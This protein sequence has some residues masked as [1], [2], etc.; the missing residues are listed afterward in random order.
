MS[1]TYDCIVIGGGPAGSTVAA[2]VAEAGFRTLLLE[3]ETLPRYRVGESLMPEAWWTLKRLGLVEPLKASRYPRKH[4]VKLVDP[5]GCDCQPFYFCEADPRQCSLAWQVV[6]SEFDELLF[7]QAAKMGAECRDQTCV[8]EVLFDGPA[9]CGVRVQGAAAGDGSTRSPGAAGEDAARPGGSRLADAESLRGPVREIRGKVIVDAAGAAS[10]LAQA[11]ELREPD[12]QGD[13]SAIWAYYVGA[14]RE[15]GI[16]EGT[17][18]LLQTR[19]RRAWFWYLPL[20]DDLVSVGVVADRE[21]LLK[22]RGRPE[23]VFE[24]E[25]VN[26]PAVARRLIDAR[27][28]RQFRVAR[29]LSYRCTRAS[30]PSWVL[31]GDALGAVDPLLGAGVFLAL[32]SGEL[33]ADCIIEGLQRGDLSAEQLGRWSGCFEQGVGRLRKLSAQMYHPD[34]SV[35]TLTQQAPQYKQRWSDLLAG[36]IFHLTD[37]IDELAENAL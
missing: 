24:E 21:Y 20:P 8:V 10:P 36:K 25:L 22:R 6:R 34:F 30:G 2:L 19:H 14:Q 5:A 33:A 18:L 31:V 26:C 3:R 13:R 32:K 16:D 29:E 35:A 15:T 23:S 4:G 9:A 7:Q 37:G 12:S 1:S 11:L 27:L 28:A 17:T